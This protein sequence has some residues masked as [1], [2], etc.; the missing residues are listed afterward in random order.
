[1]GLITKEGGT[2]VWPPVRF[3]YNTQVSKPPSPFPSKPTWLLNAK[4][5]EFAARTISPN[6]ASSNPTGSAPMMAAA[7]WWRG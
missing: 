3:S 7:T 5:C 4:D 1:M 6:A 2:V